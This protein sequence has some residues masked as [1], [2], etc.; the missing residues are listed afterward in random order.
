MR[1]SL[2][3]EVV[4]PALL[5]Y[6]VTA[7]FDDALI[8]SGDSAREFQRLTRSYRDEIWP[9]VF[10]EIDD[11]NNRVARIVRLRTEIDDRLSMIGVAP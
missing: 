10:A 11:D 4:T 1:Q 5:V 8:R 7:Q 3:G 2:L 6:T 9:E